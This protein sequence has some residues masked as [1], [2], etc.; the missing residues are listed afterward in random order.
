[1]PTFGEMVGIETPNTDGLSIL[2]TLLG[3]SDKQSQHEYLYWEFYEGGGKQAIATDRWKA[4]RLNWIEQP[5]G[6]TELYDIQND[7]AEEKDVSSQHPEIVQTMTD[8]MKESH[9]AH[10]GVISLPNSKNANGSASS[11]P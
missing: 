5:D 10:T 6:P 4:V 2:P 3:K 9:I 1:M 8:Y 11:K 7:L